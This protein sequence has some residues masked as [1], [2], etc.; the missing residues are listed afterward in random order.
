[1]AVPALFSQTAQ[2]LDPNLR[3]AR[4]IMD[5]I[6]A[7][8]PVLSQSVPVRRNVWGDAVTNGDAIGPDIISPFYS[9]QMSRDPVNVE[10]ARLRAPLSMPQRSITVEGQKVPLDAKQYDELVQLSGRPAKQYL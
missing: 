3:N 8:V 7:R 9:T 1:M 6:K 10:I 2:A 4:T 5:A